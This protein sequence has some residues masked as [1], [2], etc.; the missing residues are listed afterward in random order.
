MADESTHGAGTGG[1]SQR[2]M[3]WNDIHEPGCYLHVTSGLVARIFADD[4]AKQ[5]TRGHEGDLGGGPAF[6]LSTNP[7]TPIDVL[8]QFA[9]RYQLRI[10]S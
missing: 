1:A 8:R 6:C 3:D 7:R 9:A 4:I 10:N 2:L 5:G